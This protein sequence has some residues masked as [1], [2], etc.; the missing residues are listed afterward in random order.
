MAI[1]FIL[2]PNGPILLKAEGE[3]Y[4]ALQAEGGREL[5]VGKPTG[6]CRCGAS[7]NKP[8][9]DGAHAGR[10]YSDENRC[11]NDE[12]KDFSAPDITVHFNRSICS[13]AAACVHGLPAVFK[14]DGADWIQPAN[15]SVEEVIETVRRCPSGA[16]T[17]SLG[18]ETAVKQE[19]AVS[20][21]VVPN[22]P[23]EIKGP[24]EFE[25]TKWSRNASKTNFALC[26]CGMS[27]NAPFCDYTHGEE[28][29]DDSK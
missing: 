21:R 23:Y 28:G 15:A 16:L 12:L 10:G 5:A 11:Q 29:W 7:A 1:K 26:R 2:V 25:P 4:P 18:G 14:S 17:Y 8:F 24:V 20:I 19:S 22:G 3:D 13:G 9:C 27:K 6:L